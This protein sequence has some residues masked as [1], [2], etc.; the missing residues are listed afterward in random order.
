V[1]I[2]G[3][4]LSKKKG[5]GQKKGK[6]CSKLQK[7]PKNRGGGIHTAFVLPRGIAQRG[8]GIEGQT[9]REA[10]LTQKKEQGL[11][12]LLQMKGGGVK[13]QQSGNTGRGWEKTILSA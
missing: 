2:A 3:R 6:N 8:R 13:D 5:E 1:A 11:S 9:K 10:C 4:G 12:S 7:G